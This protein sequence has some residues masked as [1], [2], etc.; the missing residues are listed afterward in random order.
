MNKIKEARENIKDKRQSPYPT[1]PNKPHGG[2]EL[3]HK[4]YSGR[5]AILQPKLPRFCRYSLRVR[6][7]EA[8]S[9]HSLRSFGHRPRVHGTTAQIELATSPCGNVVCNKTAQRQKSRRQRQ[10]QKDK[11][12]NANS[13]YFNL[14]CHSTPK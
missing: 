3:Q 11:R 6:S 7:P 12:Q 1:P 2:S 5:V 4:I 14:Q 13:P 8:V 10:N 9:T